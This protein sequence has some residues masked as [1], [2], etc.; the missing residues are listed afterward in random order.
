[1]S[2]PFRTDLDQLQVTTRRVSD[3]VSTMLTHARELRAAIDF[4]NRWQGQAADAFRSTMGVNTGQLDR[5][6]SQ[7]EL[8]AAG[9]NETN[10][11]VVAHESDGA[12]KMTATQGE[13][14]LSGLPLNHA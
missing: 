12:R 13:G 11:G 6:V 8:M 14:S 4:V 2:S 7:L 3:T 1:M 10:Q 9:L 5:L